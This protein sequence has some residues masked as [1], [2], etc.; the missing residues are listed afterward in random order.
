VVCIDVVNLTPGVV[1]RNGLQEYAQ[2]TC[3]STAGT[4]DPDPWQPVTGLEP[5]NCNAGTITYQ[6]ETVLDADNNGVPDGAWTNITGAT[7]ASYDPPTGH[8]TV[9]RWY[10]RR[11]NVGTCV[12]YSNIVKVVVENTFC[13]IMRWK[14]GTDGFWNVPSN[15]EIFDAVSGTWKTA[16]N[17]PDQRHRVYIGDNAANRVRLVNGDTMRCADI[18]LHA[19]AKIRYY[20]NSWLAV[21]GD[22]RLY[23]TLERGVP[24]DNVNVKM[25]GYRCNGAGGYDQI[26]P[27]F[28]TNSNINYFDNFIVEMWGGDNYYTRVGQTGCTNCHLIITADGQLNLKK[29]KITVESPNL[30]RIVIKNDAPS[31]LIATSYQQNY[32][33]YDAPGRPAELSWSMGQSGLYTFPL[34]VREGGSFYA[35]P[36][37]LNY[38]ASNLFTYDSLVVSFARP[39]Y[40]TGAWSAGLGTYSTLYPECGNYGY[41]ALLNCG[42]WRM[43]PQGTVRGSNPGRYNLTV[44][45]QN[46]LYTNFGSSQSWTIV[47]RANNTPPWMLHADWTVYYP[48]NPYPASVTNSDPAYCDP[49]CDTP[50]G[51]WLWACRNEFD[52]FSDFAIAIENTPFP[53]AQELP[54]TATPVTDHIRLDWITQSE[55]NNRGFYIYRGL[56]PTALEPIA[57]QNGVGNS[58]SP[59]KYD[60]LDYDVKRSTMYYYRIKQTD[61]DG[62]FNWSNIAQAILSEYG[63]Y[64]ITVYPNPTEGTV[65]LTYS[66]TGSRKMT[67]EVYDALGKALMRKNYD[68][69]TGTATLTFDLSAYAAATYNVAVTVDG[70]REMFKVVKIK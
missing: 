15:W 70:K 3:A 24:S 40:T 41:D 18:T 9:T 12:A 36:A 67:V 32:F 64:S 54:L 52:S 50:P 38:G 16:C 2:F 43:T 69:E 42:Y 63:D 33:F 34:G 25:Y 30:Q 39:S 66:T 45:V 20:S 47:K 29:G 62:R 31:G 57:W 23:G 58:S 61:F 7:S 1:G 21:Y 28:I 26:N 56:E 55:T 68:I 19:N 65:N 8:A 22:A 5:A 14:P 44:Y 49:G 53:V 59:T 46:G 17:Y 35:T 13:Q 51:F 4:F 60:Y 48:T 37:S 27:F 11:A 10:R 6:W